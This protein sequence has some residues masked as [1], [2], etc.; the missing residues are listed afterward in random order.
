MVSIVVPVY[1]VEKYLRCCLD[2]IKQQTYTDFEVIMVDDGSTDGSG[3]ICE[4]Y[5]KADDRFHLIRQEN[6]GLASARNT[7]IR[8]AKGDFLYFVDSDDCIHISLL[9]IVV[10][11][12]ERE[13]ANIVQ[14]GFADVPSDFTDYAREVPELQVFLSL[15]KEDSVSSDNPQ[16]KTLGLGNGNPQSTGLEMQYLDKIHSYSMQE[17]LRILED[18]KKGP[19][20]NLNLRTVVV[21]TKLYRVA[22]FDSLLFP[23]GMRLHEDQMV[24]HRNYIQAGGMVHV[25]LPLHF[26]RAA[27]AS[28]IRTGWSTK[29][30]SI[31]ECYEDRLK[32]IQNLPEGTAEKQELI[33]LVYYRYLVCIFR[34]YF[35][36]DM[37]LKGEEKKQIGKQLKQKLRSELK[38]KTGHLN[39][40]QRGFFFCFFLSPTITCR[41][42]KKRW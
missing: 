33:D 20:Y 18:G 8:A 37:V 23:E 19:R 3:S 21:W 1:N 28:L 41:L 2:S 14:I 35:Y 42:Y 24:A 38:K 13:H 4:E 10:K 22:A 34:N 11:V 32:W 17:C 31:F 29:R 15:P 39:W 40:K 5:E 26:Y 27:E 36:T 16:K 9:E 12:A 6:K 7:G 25:D 30:L